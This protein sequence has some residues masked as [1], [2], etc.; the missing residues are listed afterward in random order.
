MFGH[1]PKVMFEYIFQGNDGDVRKRY[2]TAKSFLQD[3]LLELPASSVEVE[4]AHANLQYDIHVYCS[5]AK[6]PSRIQRDSY[7]MSAV[8]EHQRLKE[9]VEETC[10]GKTKGKVARLLRNRCAQSSELPFT[11]GRSCRN[12]L[13]KDGRVKKRQKSMLQGVMSAALNIAFSVW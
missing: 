10:L 5:N 11:T 3:I 8:L 1:W 12:G 2:E 9:A 4:K 7:V 13:T 6:T